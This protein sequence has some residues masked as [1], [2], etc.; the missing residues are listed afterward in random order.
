MTTG[1]TLLVLRFAF[2]AVLWLFVFV[3]V[4][5]L[6]SDLFGQRV[7][8]IPTDPKAGPSGPTTPSIPTAATAS[9]SGSAFTELLNQGGS[10]APNTPVATRLVITEGSR[11]GMEMPLGGGPITIGR[12]SESNVVIRDDY[13]STNHARLDLRA[14][15]WVVTDLESTNGTFVNGQKVS[16]PVLVAEGTPITIGTTTFELRR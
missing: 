4:F 15:G 10:T 3:I 1:L 13:T 16:A 2:L 8:T 11:E 12:S 7:R 9:A 14:E 5:A 6:R